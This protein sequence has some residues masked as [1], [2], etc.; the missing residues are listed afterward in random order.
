[1]ASQLK[2]L[3]ST[4]LLPKNVFITFI[5]NT[6]E[7][8]HVSR[9]GTLFPLKRPLHLG[10]QL[11]SG[12]GAWINLVFKDYLYDHGFFEECHWHR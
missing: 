4:L 2:K 6:L 9:S 10:W 8:S 3:I 5:F 12:F 7:K 11:R 1:M